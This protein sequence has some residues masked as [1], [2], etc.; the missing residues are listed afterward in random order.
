[1]LIIFVMN[2][3]DLNCLYLCL[4]NITG[5]SNYRMQKKI[6]IA[7]KFILGLNLM[8]IIESQSCPIP[9]FRY[10]LEYWESD[11]Y[12]L[13]IV[14]NGPLKEDEEQLLKILSQSSS[15]NNLTANLNVTKREADKTDGVPP[16]SVPQ[17]ILRYPYVTGIKK[18]IWS[19]PLNRNNVNAL[20]NSSFR[21]QISEKLL[22]DKTAV[23]ILL[24]S[25]DK[26]KDQQAYKLLEEELNRLEQTLVL[27]DFDMWWNDP[28]ENGDN[29][30]VIDFDII[31]LSRD[32]SDEEHLIQMF[33]NSETDLKDFNS[34]PIVF[35]VY[36]RGLIIYGIV[37]KG[38]NSWNIREAAEFITG[39]CSCQAKLLNPGVDLLMSVNW[40]KQIRRITD[41]GIANPLTG[42]GDFSNRE[43]E[44]RHLLET[45]TEKRLGNINNNKKEL[46]T[47]ADK[48]VYLD[49][50]GNKE[51]NGGPGG[52]ITDPGK[53]SKFLTDKDNNTDSKNEPGNTGQHLDKQNS[54]PD[55]RKATDYM[56]NSEKNKGFGST[57]IR[58]FIIIIII[59]LTGG[60]VIFL[61]AKK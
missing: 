31:R 25:G 3:N 39:E 40:D 15:G 7:L 38:I 19:G 8:I 24:E 21:K 10:A 12:N 36:G 48:V 32:N 37:G 30:P 41:P 23:W 60:I 11:N 50:F 17:M 29:K 44:A 18:V 4:N 46:K 53:N 26:Q 57:I 9:V 34:E 52:E 28:H 47:E 14:Y 16:G 54:L 6:L 58:T 55:G 13:E 42:M 49:I 43:A 35:P 51:G 59:V 45:A 2:K 56:G 20:L 33:I 22:N 5:T 27:P 61:R 1:M